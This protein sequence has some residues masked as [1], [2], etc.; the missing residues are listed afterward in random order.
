M[1]RI[2]RV[3]VP[4]VPHHVIQHGNRQMDVFFSDDDRRAYL[5]LLREMGKKHGVAYWGYCLMS[6]H[7][8]LIAVPKRKESLARG[9]GWAHQ[10]YTRSI[11]LREG[12]RGYLWHGRFFSCPLDK[13]QAQLAL[14]Y[15][16]R[17]PV[18]AKLVKHAEDWPWSSAKAHARGKA[19]KLIVRVPF[20]DSP[21]DWRS[22]LREEPAP[23]EIDL[24]RERTR[25]GR[26]LGAPRFIT[27]LERVLRRPLRRQKPGPKP[28][29]KKAPQKSGKRKK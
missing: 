3:V 15:V 27:R 9:I 16:E 14:R 5:D 18:R 7:L 13:R 19:D 22:L 1:A 12:W 8:H 11:N 4:G 28:K 21:R 2:A 20:I 6:N 26:P 29:A 25:T 10:A 24:L 23:E 17:N